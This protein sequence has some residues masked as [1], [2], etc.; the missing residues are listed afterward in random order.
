[1]TSRLLAAAAAVAAVV[2]G[3]LAGTASAAPAAAEPI[4]EAVRMTTIVDG[5][6]P[7]AQ[8]SPQTYIERAER[9]GVPLTSAERDAITASQTCWS[10][11]AWRSAQN[12]FGNTLWRNHH[13][14]NWCGDG[15]WI[16]VH[17]YVEHW[18]ET[19]APGWNADQNLEQVGDRYGVNWNQ[20][21]SWSQRRFC[22]IQYFNCVQEAH[23]YH[24]VTV[25]PNGATKWN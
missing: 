21:Q 19:F 6:E 7:V 18:A 3:A 9:A 23:P 24:N 5:S 8:I 14:V 2:T 10:W 22:L 17:A 25:F 16:R 20:Y 1:M 12:M 11:D 4:P 15:S 13:R